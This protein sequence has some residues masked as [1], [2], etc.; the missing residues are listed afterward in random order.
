MGSRLNLG[1]K[2]SSAHDRIACFGAPPN[3]LNGPCGGY[4][5]YDTGWCDIQGVTAT[6]VRYDCDTLPGM[7]GSALWAYHKSGDPCIYAVHRS[8]GTSA[9]N[10]G[11]RLT[12]F[13]V[14]TTVDLI[15]DTPSV[16]A[17]YEGC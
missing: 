6:Q 4:Q 3:G 13:W 8:E 16:Y 2:L 5:Y 12:E 1:L 7:S 14:N 9:W 11:F 10:V 15:C 17:T